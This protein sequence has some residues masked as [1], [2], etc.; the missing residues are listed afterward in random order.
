MASLGVHPAH[1]QAHS[2]G[3]PG[4]DVQQN[5]SPV[6]PLL[7]FPLRVAQSLFHLV[8]LL[9]G[10]GDPLLTVSLSH[11]ETRV[12]IVDVSEGMNYDLQVTNKE[13][14]NRAFAHSSSAYFL[15]AVTYFP[16]FSAT[17]SFWLAGSPSGSW[18]PKVLCD[19]WWGCSWPLGLSSFRWGLGG[20]VGG[21]RG[22][23]SGTTFCV[24]C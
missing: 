19:S 5:G 24:F 23:S 16:E 6:Q 20:G 12:V 14:E 11:A 17:F 1:Q 3:C 2:H 18:A 4:A 8:D 21:R 22:S 13:A 15:L 9:W 7:S 10:A